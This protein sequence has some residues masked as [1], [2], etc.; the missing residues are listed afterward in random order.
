MGF[1][2][3]A[4]FFKETVI[5]KTEYNIG[6]LEVIGKSNHENINSAVY[7]HMLNCRIPAVESLFRDA[8]THLIYTKSNKDIS[9]NITS[10]ATE[11]NTPHGGRLDLVIEDYFNQTIVLIENKIYHH[12]HNDL[13]DYWQYSSLPEE[14]KAGVLLTL[15]PH[16]IPEGLEDKFINITHKE[17]ITIVREHLQPEDIPANYQIY[18]KDFINTIDNLTNRYHMNLSAQFYFENAAQV[19]LAAESQQQAH[20]FINNQLELVAQN[21]GW[22]TYGSSMNWRN[23]WD[24]ANKLDTYLTIITKDLLNGELKFMLILELNREDKKREKEI[25]EQFK[26]HPQYQGKHKGESKKSY[27]HLLCQSYAIDKNELEN[28]AETITQKIQDDF[29]DIT[30]KVIKYL[31]P[32][33]DISIWENNFFKNE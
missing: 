30:Y 20:Q 21:L 3:L 13:N 19:K 8:L 31:Y 22:Q 28:L 23:F 16:P 12:L 33:T 1:E 24:A 11:V 6:F 9:L 5:P 26:N 4:S 27:V 15:Y 2:E 14:K 18:L 32:N 17:W 10:V 25:H 29:S 7:A